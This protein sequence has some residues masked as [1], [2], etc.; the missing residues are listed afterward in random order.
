[1]F[2][3]ALLLGRNLVEAL[4]HD[5][6]G[7]KLLLAPAAANLLESVLGVIHETLAEGAETNLNKGT[8]VENLGGNVE[9]GNALLQVRCEHHVTGLVVLIVQRQEVDL[10]EHGA[11]TDNAFAVLEKVVAKDVDELAGI[12]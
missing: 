10:A 12:L 3:K 6:L 9:V 8:V 4:N 11:G 7:K 2:L 1:M 5:T